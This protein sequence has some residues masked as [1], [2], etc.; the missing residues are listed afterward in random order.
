MAKIQHYDSGL[1]KSQKFSAFPIAQIEERQLYTEKIV[2]STPSLDM[3]FSFDF[4][5]MPKY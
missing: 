3:I 4:E 1:T 5:L 2:G